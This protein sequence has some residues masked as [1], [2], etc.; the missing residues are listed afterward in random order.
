[1][2]MTD[3]VNSKSKLCSAPPARSLCGTQP[4]CS[5]SGA[6]GFQL[7]Q[8]SG[9]PDKPPVLPGFLRRLVAQPLAKNSAAVFNGAAVSVFLLLSE[10]I[11]A[12]PFSRIVDG[13]V[14]T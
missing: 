8:N 1:M 4:S 5:S 13:H 6:A 10:T 2:A 7:T 11:T 14:G 3:V 9:V 12:R